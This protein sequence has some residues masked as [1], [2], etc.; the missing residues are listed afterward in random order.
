MGFVD[1]RRRI[2]QARVCQV[3]LGTC[4][5]HLNETWICRTSMPCSL[6]T[7]IC[8][9]DGRLESR[10]TWEHGAEG[11]ENQP[12]Y[13]TMKTTPS[14]RHGYVQGESLSLSPTH[15]LRVQFFICHQWSIL[16]DMN[17]DI[18]GHKGIQEGYRWA[19]THPKFLSP[20]GILESIFSIAIFRNTSLKR[21]KNILW[22]LSMLIYWLLCNAS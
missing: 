4:H 6:P 17:S 18:T 9:L 13:G 8:Y 10:W 16:Y 21:Q 11:S 1:S 14:D 19:I 3:C 2:N 12:I 15:Q 5:Q 7:S 20:E 22:S